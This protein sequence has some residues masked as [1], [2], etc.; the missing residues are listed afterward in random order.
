MHLEYKTFHWQKT[1]ECAS[2]KLIAVYCPMKW[3]L[4]VQLLPQ[5]RGQHTSALGLAEVQNCIHCLP[6]Y[7]LNPHICLLLYWGNADHIC[8][9]RTNIYARQDSTIGIKSGPSGCN[10]VALFVGVGGTTVRFVLAV[11]AS[12]G[13]G[14]WPQYPDW[15]PL[16]MTANQYGCH[17]AVNP[18]AT[19]VRAA[20]RLRL[21][22]VMAPVSG[23]TYCRFCGPTTTTTRESSEDVIRGV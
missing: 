10:I 13:V 6:G 21:T 17:S 15:L 8:L 16:I 2:W 22:L 11:T 4:G 19:R 7:N 3:V 9:L 18:A 12:L 23:I 14:S 1:E 20:P 5:Y